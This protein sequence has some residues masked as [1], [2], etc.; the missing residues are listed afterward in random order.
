MEIY[1]YNYTQYFVFVWEA[2]LMIIKLILSEL[3]IRCVS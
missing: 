3:K 1:L 2:C